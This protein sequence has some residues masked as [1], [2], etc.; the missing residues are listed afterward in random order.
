VQ[1]ITVF[2]K[3]DVGPRNAA[4]SQVIKQLKENLD[5]QALHALLD[6]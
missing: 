3:Q 1:F 4:K 6:R 2:W 5:V